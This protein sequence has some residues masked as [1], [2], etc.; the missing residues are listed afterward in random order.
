MRVASERLGV[1]HGHLR[2]IVWKASKE[3]QIRF[4]EPYE[5]LEYNVIP[6]AVENLEALLNEGDKTATMETVKGTIFKQWAERK[7]VGEVQH[8]VLALKFEGPDPGQTTAVMGRIVG[9]P[10]GL[11]EE[12]DE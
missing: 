1:S 11:P 7:G 3:G 2:T 4:D 8:T 6:K 10:K 5:R 9:K 12:S